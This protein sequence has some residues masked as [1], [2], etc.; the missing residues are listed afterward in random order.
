M[1]DYIYTNG[2]LYNVDELAHANF[3]YIKRIPNGKGGWKYIYDVDLLK[4]NLKN[5]KNKAV[6]KARE[7]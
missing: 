6:N 7:V 4:S 2:E 1:S 3:K 5:V